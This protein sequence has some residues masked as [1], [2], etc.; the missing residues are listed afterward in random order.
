M[1]T[2]EFVSIVFGFHHLCRQIQKSLKWRQKDMREEE[3]EA[4]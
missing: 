2:N 1:N 3:K 4:A